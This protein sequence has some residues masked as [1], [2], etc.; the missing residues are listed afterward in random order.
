[1]R[2]LTLPCWIAAL[3][4]AAPAA[5]AQNYSVDVHAETNGLDVKVEP[6][7]TDGL[8]AINLAN[9]TDRKVRCDLRYD[10]S[11][12]PIY[13]TTTYLEPHEKTQSVFRAKRKWL[14]VDVSVECKATDK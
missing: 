1:M 10:A 8:L 5:M 7:P 9:G 14:S 6:V 12:Q 3:A 13:R 4:L 11:P 2:V